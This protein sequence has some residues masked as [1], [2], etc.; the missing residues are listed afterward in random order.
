MNIGQ[1]ARQTGVAIDTIRY[2]ERQGLLP[3][4]RRGANGYRQY[5]PAD[6]RR[7][8]FVRRAKELGFSLEE[9]GSLLA[10][11]DARGADMAQV[12][13][14]AQEKLVM[15]QERIDELQRVRNA[16]RDLVE[17]CPGHGALQDC[18]IMGALAE[19]AA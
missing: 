7:L 14:T 15:I 4:A 6:T 9:I 5:G 3:A 11:S 8:R 10:L 18:P 17:A 16:L 2:Y 19:E 12:R 13:V 1:L